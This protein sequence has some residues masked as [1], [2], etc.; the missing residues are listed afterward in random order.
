MHTAADEP[1][2]QARLAALYQGLQEAGWAIGRNIKIEAR[3][4]V[5]DQ[6]R[7]RRDAAELV[8]L[9]PEVIL[10][11]VGGT[12]A[13]LLEA[14]RK[15]PIVFAQGIDPVGNL[16]VASL[17]RPGGNATGFTQFEYALSAK[18]LELLKEIAP[19]V[20][21]VAVLREVGVAAVGQWAIIQ[22]AAPTFGMEV[23]PIELR[24]AAGIERDLSLFA[25]EP[26]GGLVVAVSALSQLHRG[27]IVRL[28]AQHG[29][30]A[31]Y[32]YR[33]FT[34]GGGLM[35]YGPDLIALYRS[36]ASYVDRILR[37]EKPA[38]LPVQ[39]ATKHE[40]TINLKTAKALGLA[41][42]PALLAR[43]D[44]IIE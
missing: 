18:W 29:L 43:A 14:T 21:R 10:A 23:S 5:G 9:N 1:E 13:M 33:F 22:A 7:L 12:T 41:V 44:E 16:H 3:W 8:A 34:A 37:G 11:G 6:A 30:P 32:P 35:S 20:K 25:R 4:S 40:L 39:A 2:A 17:A 42:P 36:A 27:L 28:A 31:V 19:Q 15:I 26:N 38:D 24:N